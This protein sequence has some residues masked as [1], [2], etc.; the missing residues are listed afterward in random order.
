ML[1]RNSYSFCCNCSSSACFAKGAITGIIGMN[2]GKG[3]RTHQSLQADQ[4]GGVMDS[5]VVMPLSVENKKEMKQEI[6]INDQT[7]L[8]SMGKSTQQTQLPIVNNKMKN[9]QNESIS[10]CV[11]SSTVFRGRIFCF[12]NS[13]PQERVSC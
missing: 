6:R 7:F 2:Q 1:L 3:S 11:K 8:K 13:F 9:M 10:Q 12:S 4:V 5:R